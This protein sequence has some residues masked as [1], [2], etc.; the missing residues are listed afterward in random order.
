MICAALLLGREGVNSFPLS[1]KKRGAWGESFSWL[2]ANL[3]KQHYSAGC[4]RK[5][6]LLQIKPEMA[7]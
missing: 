7:N 1:S 3:S 6:E 5:T 4:F 2:S